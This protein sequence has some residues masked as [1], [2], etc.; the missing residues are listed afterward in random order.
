MISLLLRLLSLAPTAHQLLL[1]QLFSSSLFPVLYVIIENV[2]RCIYWNIRFDYLHLSALPYTSIRR[3]AL[4]HRFQLLSPFSMW[5]DPC[6]HLAFLYEVIQNNLTVVD[7][8]CSSW[9]NTKLLCCYITW[10]RPVTIE[11]VDSF[12]SYCWF[13]FKLFFFFN[14]YH[15]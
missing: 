12:C 15:Y 11:R 7:I 8:E 2:R 10:R 3:V 5:W 13:D 9:L 1:F 4:R 14:F 6:L